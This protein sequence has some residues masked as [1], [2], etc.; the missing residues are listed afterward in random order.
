MKPPRILD[1]LSAENVHPEAIGKENRRKNDGVEL[2]IRTP[3]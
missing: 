2:A 3:Q 1:S